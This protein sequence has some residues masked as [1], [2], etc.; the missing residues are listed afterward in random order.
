[1]SN[2]LRPYLTAIRSTLEAALCLRSFPSQVVRH[3][4]MQRVS[5]PER[6]ARLSFTPSSS[7][8]P[9]HSSPP[10]HPPPPCNQKG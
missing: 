4:Q 5:A 3:A 9:P 8:L 7:P 1:M 6:Q 10:S 2:T